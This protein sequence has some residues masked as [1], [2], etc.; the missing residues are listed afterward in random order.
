MLR[1]ILTPICAVE[2]LAPEAL[3]DAAEQIALENADECERRSWVIPSARL[4]GLLF[5]AMMWRSDSSYSSFKKF[6]GIVGIL[7]LLY[8]R[9][10][11]DSGARLAYVDASE[12]EWKPWVYA[13]TRFVGLLYVL[14]GLSAL[15]EGEATG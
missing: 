15:R 4:E 7:A 3:V 8:P 14:V 9:V 11:V 5:L 13:G 10:Y 12:C 2:V 6:L 1:K